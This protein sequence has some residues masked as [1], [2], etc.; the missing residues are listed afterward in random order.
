MRF[1]HGTTATALFAAAE[2]WSTPL[3]RLE[4]CG[5]Q[6]RSL[7]CEAGRRLWLYEP[8]EA[9][10]L[11]EP[12]GLAAHVSAS[13]IAGLAEDLKAFLAACVEEP[14]T[15][16]AAS[17]RVNSTD[18][19]IGAARPLQ[20]IEAANESL[21]SGNVVEFEPMRA[22]LAAVERPTAAV[23]STANE[24]GSNANGTPPATLQLPL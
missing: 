9:A 17:P 4:I 11:L 10:R 2:S 20:V 21:A 19:L 6:G 12:P 3:P 14:S 13:N 1:G 23:G 16:G 24:S 7:V 18:S 8:R 15:A 22:R 5:T